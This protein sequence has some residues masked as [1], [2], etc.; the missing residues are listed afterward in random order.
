M[1]LSG[2]A[3]ISA[4]DTSVSVTH[5]YGASPPAVLIEPQTDLGG[6]SVWVSGK[7]ATTFVINISSSDVGDHTFAWAI[8]GVTEAEA[9]GEQYCTVAKAKE[10]AG[11]AY[12]EL[13][14]ADDNA[15]ETFISECIDRASRFIDRYCQRNSDYFNGGATI[16][17]YH[18][19]KSASAALYTGTDRANKSAIREYQLRQTPVISITSV[20]VNSATIGSSDSYTATTSYRSDLSNGR[21]VFAQGS[22]PAEG[23]LNVRFIYVAGYSSVP[24]EI[25]WAC[26]DLV[27]NAI[28][29]NYE[30]QVNSRVRFTK[31]AAV[32]SFNNSSIFTAEIK[33][34][35]KPYKKVNM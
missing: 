13:G 12:T 33:E 19:G 23:Q 14:F 11:Y 18:D 20:S 9:T 35:L 27:A 1:A 3:T 31:P 22:E 21:I 7:T 2:S 4:G 16:T 34:M 6:R 25:R 10:A 28:K 24:D 30:D 8:G 32:S 17:E 29:K 26:E 15:Y 5:T